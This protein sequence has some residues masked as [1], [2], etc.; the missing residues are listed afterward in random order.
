MDFKY[1][2]LLMLFEFRKPYDSVHHDILLR[3]IRQADLSVA[4]IKWIPSYLTSRE[5]AVLDTKGVVSSFTPLNKGV[6]QG[7]V[8]V[9]FLFLCSS[10]E[11]Y[12]ELH[13]NKI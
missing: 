9:P 10:E 13:S 1:V 6:L 2:I 8:L 3:K 7:S 4:A 11:C 5:Q 12:P